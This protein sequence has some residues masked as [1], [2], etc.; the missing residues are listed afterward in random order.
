MQT[1]NLDLTTKSYNI[2]IGS[3]IINYSNLE[4]FASNKEVLLIHDG[5]TVHMTEYG[6]IFTNASLGTVNSDISGGSV[7][8]LVTPANINTTVKIQRLSVTV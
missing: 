7:R 3:K 1:V 4:K 5:T 2:K 8:L 6:T